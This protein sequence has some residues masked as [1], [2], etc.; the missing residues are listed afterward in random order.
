M[1]IRPTR[2]TASCT[3][4][5]LIGLSLIG[6]GGALAQATSPQTQERITVTGSNIKRVSAE[7]P[8]PV[9]VI[10]RDEIE[11]SAKG[12]VGEFLRD[13]TANSGGSSSETSTNS[14][15]GAAGISLRGL[16]QKSTL[17]LINGRRMANHAFA[18]QDTFVDLNSIPKSAVQRI[19]VLK[20]GASAIYGS[21]AI[22]GVVNI[23]LRKDFKGAEL[24]G[25]IGSASQGGLG[26]KGF[27][28]AAGW[29][30]ADDALNVMGV[31]DVFK[32]DMLLYSQR[33]W[34]NGLD[35][36]F[37]PGG[38]FFPAS[39]GGTWVRPAGVT[40]GSARTAL[41]N[42]IQPSF[43]MPANI[44]SA[45][46]TGRACGYSV[47]QY[48]TS[49]PKAD[50]MGLFTRATYR[51]S[52]DADLF[53]ELS[54]SSN[55]SDWINQPQ[56]MTNTSVSFNPSTGGFISF[57]NVIPN[58]AAHAAL[59][60]TNPYGRP[61]SLNYTFFD[62]GAR[63]FALDTKTS[64]AVVGASASMGGYD[65]QVAAGRSDSKITQ[66]TGNQV[67]TVQLRAAIDTGNYNFLAPTSE[68]TA[69]LRVATT[70]NATSKLSFADVKV[71]GELMQ[72]PA[73][74]L[75]FAAGLDV[76]SESITDTPDP[77][78]QQGR[79]IGTGASRTDGSRNASA[80]YMEM[81][82]PATKGLELQLAGRSDNYSDFGSAF[83]PKVGIKFTASPR[84]ALRASM[85]KGFRAPTLVENANSSSLG[86]DSVL[87]PV[88]NNASTIIGVLNSGSK[89]LKAERS[90]SSTVGIV[91][92]P[93]NDISVALDYYTIEQ[94]DLVALN[95]AQFIVRNPSVFPG[96]VVRDPASNQ[97][98]V[99]YDNFSNQ[100]NVLTK[101]VDL[102]VR[103]KLGANSYG[104][105]AARATASY[106]M[107]WSFSPRAGV[108]TVDYAHRNDGPNGSLP[109]VK[110]RA[111][112]DWQMA[113]LS[114]TLAANHTG[115]YNQKNTTAALA[116]PTVQ[117]HTTFD[118]YMAYTGL[119]NL[120]ATLSVENLANR[121]PPW[122]IASGLGISNSQYTLRGRYTRL[123]LEY[124]F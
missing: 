81:S 88:R 68:Q 112:L 13:I 17:V 58:I 23:I 57:P 108:P 75:G 107:E 121:N 5:G 46:V 53:A 78:L 80:L 54:L 48:L 27:N 11:R 95:G 93:V 7:G 44:I 43:N 39:S 74:P 99:V 55:Q 84:L 35:F 105:F 36:R 91:F 70:R 31:V 1:R 123:G 18:G 109:L 119:K 14:Q 87:D 101:G 115:S 76:R 42:C 8:A 45:F 9:Q 83:S 29:S 106:L 59:N 64:R 124:K 34:L 85:A 73:G 37:L 10:S 104:K 47:D 49:Y 63:T 40:T 110:L 102:D 103:A 4:A 100:S 19:E 114:A 25:N 38:T 41:P 97:I 67:D 62:V 89:N 69:R 33:P 20:D 16:G 94:K 65:W 117:S 120:K 116:E 26:E 61:A 71:S 32:R 24:G 12:T 15:S 30:S 66:V 90:V 2:L 82:V 96:A 122:D 3:Q 79:L 92:E 118:L 56:T 98:L 6:A 51:L 60:A 86:F 28:A 21:D 22:A 52:P 77:I 72:L 111:A 50:R 113:A